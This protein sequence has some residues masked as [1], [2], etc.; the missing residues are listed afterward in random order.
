MF[1]KTMA[2][3]FSNNNISCISLAIH[4]GTTETG[5]SK[6]YIGRSHLNVHSPSETANNILN[7]IDKKDLSDSGCFF[8]WDGSEVAW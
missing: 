6:P 3:E 5:L 8:S 4:P 1:I 7:V 2:V